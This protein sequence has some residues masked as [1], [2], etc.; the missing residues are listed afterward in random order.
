MSELLS[1]T[2]IDRLQTGRGYIVDQSH[3]ALWF[4]AVLGLGEGLDHCLADLD[5][6]GRDV[7]PVLY[8]SRCRIVVANI[9]EPH[10][11]TV[12]I[13][14]QDGPLERGTEIIASGLG[15][16]VLSELRRTAGI[17][18]LVLTPLTD[19]FRKRFANEKTTLLQTYFLCRG[20]EEQK[21]LRLAQIFRSLQDK[22]RREANLLRQLL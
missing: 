9:Y 21:R 3:P 19:Q 10:P 1:P 14:Q 6:F 12:Q 20:G 13:V 18:D 17:L 4:A 7:S 15:L 22:N 2:E 8:E 16:D 11:V 5:Q